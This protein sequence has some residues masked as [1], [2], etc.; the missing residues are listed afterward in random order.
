[1]WWLWRA[2]RPRVFRPRPHGAPAHIHAWPRPRGRAIPRQKA[3][4]AAA[5]PRRAARPLPSPP[6]SLCRRRRRHGRAASARSAPRGPA[7]ALRPA[8]L[9]PGSSS[10]GT[11]GSLAGLRAPLQCA[12]R[13]TRTQSRRKG[14]RRGETATTGCSRV[15]GG[16]DVRGRGRLRA[17]P[18]RR[19]VGPAAQQLGCGAPEGR[20]ARKG[21]S[22]RYAPFADRNKPDPLPFVC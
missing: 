8:P 6:A 17:G 4:A 9:R 13:F 16:G 10:R 7:A 5:E 2:G 3:A 18:R 15:R 14:G 21:S 19:L 1:M 22:S 11:I 20:G 12:A